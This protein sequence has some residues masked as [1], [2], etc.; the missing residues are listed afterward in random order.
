M[1]NRTRIGNSPTDY[2]YEYLKTSTGL[3]TYQ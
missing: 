2:W 3:N 1:S